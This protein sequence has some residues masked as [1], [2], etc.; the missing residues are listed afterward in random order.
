MDVGQP[1][2]F[3]EEEWSTPDCILR[4]LPL[5]TGFMVDGADLLLMMLLVV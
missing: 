4:G 5:A 3:G 2:G 1:A